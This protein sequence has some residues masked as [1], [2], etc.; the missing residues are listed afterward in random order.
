[1]C[2]CVVEKI[3]LNQQ[4]CKPI[5]IK[6]QQNLQ[7]NI[8]LLSENMQKTSETQAHRHLSLNFLWPLCPLY[9]LHNLTPV[10][11]HW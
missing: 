4:S 1:M 5:H 2:Y 3:I 11:Q 10:K 7:E 6:M 9:T 8:L